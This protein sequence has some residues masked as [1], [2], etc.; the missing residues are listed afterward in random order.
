MNSSERFVQT[1]RRTKTTASRNFRDWQESFFDQ[2]FGLFK[3]DFPQ[4]FTKSH[5]QIHF[6]Q[7]AAIRS[8]KSEIGHDVF[9]FQIWIA[10]IIFQ[11]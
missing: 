6:E 1:L 8:R 5:A 2:R 9:E 7:G 10:V 3:S 11:K 4:F